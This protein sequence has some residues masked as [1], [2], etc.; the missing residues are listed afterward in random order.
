M[1]AS[2]TSVACSRASGNIDDI[3]RVSVDVYVAAATG[4]SPQAMNVHLCPA[5][6][7]EVQLDSQKH[8]QKGAVKRAV[9]LDSQQ[10]LLQRSMTVRHG[11]RVC[12]HT[13]IYLRVSRTMTLSLHRL[14]KCHA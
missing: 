12:N 14:S 3:V 1:A 10:P 5:F 8:K 7:V 11:E 6:Q 2:F 13:K 9:F 4:L